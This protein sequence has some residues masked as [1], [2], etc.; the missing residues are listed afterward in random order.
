MKESL[1]EVV[2]GKDRPFVRQFVDTQMFAVWSDE[3]ISSNFESASISS[4]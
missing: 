1:L 3:L 2:P 4:P